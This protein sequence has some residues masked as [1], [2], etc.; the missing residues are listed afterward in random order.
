VFQTGIVQFDPGELSKTISIA[1][2]GDTLGE[3]N[4][5]FLVGLSNASD[6]LVLDTGSATATGTIKSDDTVT[7]SAA[8]I[9][10]VN[11]TILRV[12]DS[13]TDAATVAA[14]INAGT[15]IF[16]DYIQGLANQ[17]KDT[18]SAIL[19]TFQIMGTIPLLDSTG[20]DAETNLIAGINSNFSA[21]AG[22]VAIGASLA[23]SHFAPV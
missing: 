18:T 12:A 23:D 15:L 16:D 1:V 21:A 19:S 13:D 3:S 5:T 11:L 4:E 14:N 17:A 10:A 9:Q 22:W 20:L 6:G 7:K 2:Q 8:D